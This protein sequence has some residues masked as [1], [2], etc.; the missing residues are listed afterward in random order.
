MNKLFSAA[1]C[2]ASLLALAACGK[3][4]SYVV[5]IP[6]DESFKGQEMIIIDGLSPDHEHPDTLG[7]Q[8]VNDSIVTFMGEIKKPT[9]A[10]AL[11]GRY[12]VAQFILEPGE[13]T[14]DGQGLAHGTKLNDNYSAYAEKSGET[15]AR[16]NEAQSEAAFDSIF[17][18][19]YIPGAIRFIADNASSPI[20]PMVFGSVAPYLSLDQIDSCF[21]A[22]TV[23]AADEDFKGIRAAAANKVATSAGKKY[24]DLQVQQ[25]DSTM[26]ALSQY[27]IPGKYTLVDFWASWCG[28]CRKE[29][30]GIIE[31]YDK[32][33]AKGLEVVG[34]AVWDQ[35]DNTRQAIEALGINYPVIFNGTRQTTDTYGI[36]AIPCVVLIGP[37][38]TI[39]ARD[40]MGEQLHDTVTDLFNK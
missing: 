21:E 24:T 36:M 22:D 28:P 16:M 1:I 4:D 40:L 35:P 7:R 29:I 20:V 12:P 11:L 3:K 30:P 38:G 2:G 33:H 18:G 5:A 23:L 6:A 14:F 13:I 31:L 15:I 10:V 37:D 32:Y 9:F 8:T 39:I 34:V 26:V 19:E 25:D 27:V 17:K